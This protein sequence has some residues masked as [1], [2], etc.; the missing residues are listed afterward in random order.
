MK[1]IIVVTGGAGFV[2]TN[3]IQ[4]LTEHTKYK[5]ISIDNYSSGSKKNHLKSKN[6]SYINGDT[7]NIDNILKK[8]SKK[9]LTIFHFGEFSRIHQSFAHS[10]KC[11]NSNISGTSKVINYCLTHNIKIIYSATSASLGNLGNDQNLSPY[12]FTKSKNLKLL[13]HLRKWFKLPYEILYFYNVYGARQIKDG[14]MSTVIGVFEKQ[15]LDKKPLTVVKPGTQSR[16][17]THIDDTVK[18]C[19]YAWKENKNR[20]YQ[21]SSN[22]S[23]TI[24]QVAKLFNSKINFIK[25]K[26][27]ERYKSSKVKNIGE[28][29]IFPIQCKK[30]LDIYIK[31][32][33]KSL[34]E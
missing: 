3:L 18:G 27:G 24:L 20:H 25:K 10:I 5:I 26:L 2:G 28:F 16:I 34:K 9:I 21:L 19:I 4:Y 33:I 22:K 13:I 32:Y 17:F 31:D 7:N 15:Y 11:F 12:A 8:K 23:Y 6:I 1:N 14:P 30:K 29:K